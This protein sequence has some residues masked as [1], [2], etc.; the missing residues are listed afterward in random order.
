VCEL[1]LQLNFEEIWDFRLH[2]HDFKATDLTYRGSEK[3]SKKLKPFLRIRLESES[4]LSRNEVESVAVSSAMPSWT[5][6]GKKPI[7][8]RGTNMQ[9]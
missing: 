7:K 8:F 4:F 6:V 9:L 1:T 5:R 2:F 3:Y